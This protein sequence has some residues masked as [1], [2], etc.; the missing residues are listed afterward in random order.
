MKFAVI[1]IDHGH[2]YMM[3]ENL[4]RVPG[5]EC[6]GYYT[7]LPALE[8]QMERA[9]PQIP[10]ARN[11]AE[12]LERRDV[13]LIVSASVPSERGPL[14]VRAMNHGKDFFGDAPF[15]T[16]PEQ[17]R[18]I[19]LTQARTHKSVFIYL[20]ERLLS[21]VETVAGRLVRAGEIGRPVNFIGLEPHKL[22][23]AKRPAWQF[24]RTQSGGILNE[25]G[26]HILD[27]FAFLT[28]QVV[29]SGRARIGNVASPENPDF[30]DLCDM[31]FTG[32]AG[33]TG[34][35]RADWLTPD[36]LPSFG[37]IRCV[38]VGTEGFLEIRKK[39]DLAVDNSRY[40]GDQLLI[41]SKKREPERIDCRHVPITFHEQLVRDVIQETNRCVP[42]RHF[43]GLMKKIFEMQA[44]AE[45]IS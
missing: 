28:N 23:A 20:R 43:F 44:A 15:P 3:I 17:L 7:D 18:L 36:T 25:L 30:D 45:R 9:F 42:H 12:L 8:K 40:T 27:S 31:T 29:E 37:D 35:A 1:G 41:C 4:L 19:E 33:A 6:A 24:K 21:R 16:T 11:E 10:L 38:V 22:M 13:D 34:Y 39:I 26:V 2:I 5:V 14:A 32:A